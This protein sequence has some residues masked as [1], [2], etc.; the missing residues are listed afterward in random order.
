MNLWNR[1]D[2]LISEPG[3][4]ELLFIEITS[5]ASRRIKGNKPYIGQKDMQSQNGK[6]HQR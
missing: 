4:E 3:L 1:I 6:V 2:I 5:S